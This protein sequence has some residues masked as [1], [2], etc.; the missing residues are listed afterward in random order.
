MK[1]NNSD[2]KEQKL[3]LEKVKKLNLLLLYREVDKS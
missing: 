3:K 2:K 1:P